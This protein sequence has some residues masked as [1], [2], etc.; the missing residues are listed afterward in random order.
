MPGDNPYA[1]VCDASALKADA[2][3]LDM[4]ARMQLA[5]KRAGVEIRIRRVP[6]DLLEL[7]AFAGVADAL[8]VEPGREP[9]Q[10]EDALGVEEE[11]HLG[12]SPA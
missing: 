8:G 3:S 12:D 9:E 5:A 6:D 11:G 2:A 4:L 10:R 7:L 1:I